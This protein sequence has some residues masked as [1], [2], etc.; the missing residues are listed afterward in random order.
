MATVVP[1]YAPHA[2]YF[3]AAETLCCFARV[4]YLLGDRQRAARLYAEAAVMEAEGSE[5]L[6]G[7]LRMSLK[8]E[9][10]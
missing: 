7:E 4:A 10:R 6:V 1:L 8:E 2:S 5:A 9:L 3:D